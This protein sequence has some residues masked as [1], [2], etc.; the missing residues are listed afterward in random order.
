M[1]ANRVW[2][3]SCRERLLA[4]SPNEQPVRQMRSTMPASA[5]PKP[6]HI[7]AMP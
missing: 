5:W 6:M 7:V 2:V 1:R 3:N 4:A